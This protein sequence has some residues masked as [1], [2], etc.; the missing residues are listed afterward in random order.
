[1]DV[2]VPSL[3]PAPVDDE[4]Y[5]VGLVPYPLPPPSVILP[6]PV[7]VSPLRPF[8]EFNTLLSPRTIEPPPEL[9]LLD[10]NVM[11]PL[12]VSTERDAIV[13]MSPRPF[14]SMSAPDCVDV[15]S[16]SKKISPP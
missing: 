12:F 2:L 16:F 13:S 8:D 1:M 4:L 3:I 10:H 11:S 6:P 7:S 9:S 5:P 15:R 14:T